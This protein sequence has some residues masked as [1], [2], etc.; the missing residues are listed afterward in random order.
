MTIWWKVTAQC[1]IRQHLCLP[2]RDSRLVFALPSPVKVTDQTNVTDWV[3]NQLRCVA[4]QMAATTLCS[5]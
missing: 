4:I 5:I 2:K 3:L 1:D